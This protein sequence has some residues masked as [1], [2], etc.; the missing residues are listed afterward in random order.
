MVHTSRREAPGMAEIHTLDTDI[1][2][3]LEGSATLVTGGMAVATKTITP[4][5][6]E[7]RGTAIRDW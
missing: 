3:V 6:N 1:V 4:T 2:Y 7:L 5:P